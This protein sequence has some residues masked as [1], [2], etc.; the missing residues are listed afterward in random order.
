MHVR[1]Q[2]TQAWLVHCCACTCAFCRQT[3]AVMMTTPLRSSVKKQQQHEQRRITAA[4]PAT[5]HAAV[6]AGSA[7]VMSCEGP[8]EA[9]RALYTPGA[10]AWPQYSPQGP[11]APPPSPLSLHRSQ[12]WGT[13]I[14]SPA[15]HCAPVKSAKEV[16]I[17]SRL[18][19]V[20][21]PFVR[22]LQQLFCSAMRCYS[23][24][25][26]EGVTAIPWMREC[27]A[28]LLTTEL[29]IC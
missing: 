9:R 22:M 6:A 29:G 2:M 18:T 19:K 25:L 10:Q 15:P 16:S 24:P 17:P 27:E 7:E 26:D 5:R 14:C 13:H 28:Q 3:G 23:N 8:N 20:Q 4:V 1:E 12:S 21:G 11:P